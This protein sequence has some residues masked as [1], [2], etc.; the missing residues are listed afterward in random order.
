M[1]LFDVLKLTFPI[2]LKTIFADKT[3]IDQQL[4]G[5][6]RNSSLRAFSGN[7]ATA[8]ENL[9]E[10]GCWCYFYDNVGRGKSQPVDEIDGFCKTLADGYRCAMIDSEAEGES[11][12][13]WETDYSPGSGAG[14]NIF[15]K[16]VELNPNS[17]C[18]QRSCT[19]EGQFVDNLFAFLLSGS[20]IDYQS[21]SHK[22]GFQPGVSTYVDDNGNFI[23]GNCPVKI[24][25]KGVSG[26]KSCCGVYPFRYPFKTLD[27]D[28]A[29]CGTRTY[30]TQ[31]LNCCS[32]GQVKARAG[33]TLT[34]WNHQ[35]P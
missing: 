12:I 16:C 13:P 1:Q 19:V 31:N 18:A 6:I 33:N 22:N 23:E 5:L 29:C 3:H 14:I 24:G 21:Y 30:N 34:P 20:M 35:S 25:V 4:M 26:E 28:R 9:D 32:N 11:C 10:Y 15:R 8:I 2:F 7:I 27:G 17:P